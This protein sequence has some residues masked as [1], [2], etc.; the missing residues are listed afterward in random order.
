MTGTAAGARWPLSV[1]LPCHG[2]RD[3]IARSLA[4]LAA[5][6]FQG[7]E[8]LLVGDDEQSPDCGLPRDRIRWI[9]HSGAAADAWNAG[10]SEAS[11]ICLC[12]LSPGDQL[13]PAYLETSLF[14]FRVRHPDYYRAA[15]DSTPDP[16]P[17]IL[18]ALP[19]LKEGGAEVSL[20]RLCA[21]LKDL[22]FRIL[23]V[24][25][26][27]SRL[28]PGDATSWFRPHVAGV[29]PLPRILDAGFWRA[30][31]FY[32]LRQHSISL[33]WQAGSSYLYD[34]L[35]DIRRVFPQLAVADL[36]F[37]PS[38]HAATYLNRRRFIDRAVVE[39]AGMM[40]W[41]S[42]Q[43][44]NESGVSLIPNGIDLDCYQPQ[45][46]KEWRTGKPR[47]G[48]P[49]SVIGFFGRLSAEKGPDIFLQIAERFADRKD[50]EFLLC[51]SG[52]EE[53]ALRSQCRELGL[54]EKVHFLGFVPAR[55]YLPC[56]DL[57]VVPSRI[58]G[59][60]NI[61]MESL[62][63]GVPVVASRTGGI[64]GMAPEGQGTR[65]CETGNVEE[66]HR[67]IGQLIDD[68]EARARLA[69]AGRRW[70]EEHFSSASA[71][72]SYAALFRALIQ[73]RQV[74]SRPLSAT[75]LLAASELPPRINLDG[76]APGAPAALFRFV[77]SVLSPVRVTGN[78]RT[79]VFYWKLRR[80]AG[81]SQDLKALF[82]AAYYT[83]A[84]PDAAA[85]RI[86]PLWHYLL[87]G[88]RQGYDPS[89]RFHTRYYLTVYRD[90]ARAGVNPLLHYLG[91]GRE[92]GRTGLPDY[93]LA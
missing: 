32:L 91:A 24:T 58:D 77:Q 5:Q 79:L 27:P 9:R 75:E 29:Y 13:D 15:F 17:A 70:A 44:V 89:P 40:Q 81:A 59:R 35:P 36:L 51:G 42:G 73:E 45:P 22:G 14:L 23:V 90:V 69:A 82:D 39:H 71:G 61:V 37:N 83:A 7:F 1:V 25:T 12:F 57:T 38:G 33:I 55:E 68:R 43:G 72:Q 4:S 74:H 47:S 3:A 56:C 18:L 78:L 49:P 20:S 63:M 48:S 8:V 93:D 80:T 64:P 86:S 21:Q 88:F 52:R 67:A 19:Y 92:E 76:A 87:C 60:P 53:A 65:L 34:L 50:L 10:A 30:F 54:E 66:F 41:L 26:E 31:L 28:F 6:T 62:A 84:C 2:E 46:R 11:S 85:S 16:A